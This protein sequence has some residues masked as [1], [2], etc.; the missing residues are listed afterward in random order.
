MLI[1][2]F[3]CGGYAAVSIKNNVSDNQLLHCSDKGFH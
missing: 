2:C 3:L 1:Y